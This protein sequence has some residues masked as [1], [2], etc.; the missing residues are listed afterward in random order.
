MIFRGFQGGFGI[1]KL[2]MWVKSMNRFRVQGVI[3]AILI[4]YPSK[5]WVENHVFLWIFD[6]YQSI[7]FW[8]IPPNYTPLNEP[9]RVKET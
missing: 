1:R 8:G 4:S 5:D 2:N 9:V 3:L 6:I 7:I